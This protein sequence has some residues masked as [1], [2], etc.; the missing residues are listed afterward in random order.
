MTEDGTNVRAPSVSSGDGNPRVPCWPLGLPV[1]AR[2]ALP[3]ILDPTQDGYHDT[4]SPD[5]LGPLAQHPLVV[6]VA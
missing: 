2:Q 4:H 3:A 6:S 1:P 5:D